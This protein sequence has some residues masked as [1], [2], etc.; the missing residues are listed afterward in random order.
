MKTKEIILYALASLFLLGFFLLS[1]FLRNIDNQTTSGIIN[2]LKD[3]V[4]LILGY[5]FGSSRG[6]SEKNELLGGK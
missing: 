6:S 1:W 2:T 5:F 4:I 3:G